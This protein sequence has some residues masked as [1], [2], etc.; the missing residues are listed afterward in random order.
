[1]ALR[2][3]PAPSCQKTDACWIVGEGIARRGD[4]LAAPTMLPLERV[5]RGA[6]E[7]DASCLADKWCMLPGAGDAE[8][9][10]A[11]ASNFAGGPCTMVVLPLAAPVSLF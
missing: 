2:E 4:M 9:A 3:V 6:A 8:A 5:D 1:M 10:G 11:G 7:R